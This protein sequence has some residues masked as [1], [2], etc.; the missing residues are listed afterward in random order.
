MHVAAEFASMIVLAA[1]KEAAT[2]ST[3]SAVMEVTKRERGR[4]RI[5]KRIL[6]VGSKL[7]F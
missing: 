2:M 1:V 5:V 6:M 4:R 3:A 7:R